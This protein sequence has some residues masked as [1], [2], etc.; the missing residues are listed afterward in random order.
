MDLLG[1][2]SRANPYPLWHALRER[3]PFLTADGGSLVLGRYEDCRRVLRDP[4]MS[5][6]QEYTVAADRPG[7]Q[8]SFLVLD[9]PDHTRLRRLVA[10]A[11][12][13]R[14]IANLEPFATGLVD[15][16]LD[17]AAERGSIDIMGDLAQQLPITAICRWLGVPAEDA[18]TLREWTTSASRSMDPYVL[19][20]GRAMAQIAEAETNLEDYFRAL[21]AERRGR[22]GDD[23][24]SHLV[25]VEEQGDR[26]TTEELLAT[27]NLLLV[28]GHETTVNLIGNGVL[29]LLGHPD[30]LAR[31]RAD[32]GLAHAAVEEALRFAAPVQMTSR[33]ATVETPFGDIVIPAGTR[34]TILLAAAGRDP[35]VHLEPD[36]FVIDRP[37]QAHLAFSGGPHFCLGAALGRLEAAVVFRQFATRV[38]GASLAEV[39]Y[40]PH[41]NLR[42][43]DRLTVHFDA[44]RR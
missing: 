5:S 43:P 8:P 37:G 44:V 27:L 38:H 26:L 41:L 15:H 25:T 14:A 16:V 42:G 12:T 22:P 10:K 1:P 11:F 29:A 3:S 24:L 6:R 34:V 36:R 18:A 32:P 17:T 19:A 21:V 9:P 35:S 31:L 28:A 4:S 7:L 23:L 40:R 13:P 30:E 39:S 2:G 20:D 33:L